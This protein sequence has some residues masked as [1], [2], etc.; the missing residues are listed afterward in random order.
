MNFGNHRPQNIT[1]PDITGK[2]VTPFL[3]QINSG[4]YDGEHL[5]PGVYLVS[6]AVD[7]HVVTKRMIKK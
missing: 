7:G 5:T 1:I 6:V 2:I 3:R 4:V